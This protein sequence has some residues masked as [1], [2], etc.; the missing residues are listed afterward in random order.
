[1]WGSKKVT[2]APLEAKYGF[3]YLPRHLL[4]LSASECQQGWPAFGQVE[5]N[6]NIQKEIRNEVPSS[7]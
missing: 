3:A 7:S 4:A 2:L 1:L 5:R 6:S